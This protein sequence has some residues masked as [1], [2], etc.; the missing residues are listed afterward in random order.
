MTH[1][2]VCRCGAFY[3][4]RMPHDLCPTKTWDCPACEM[5]AL[6]DAMSRLAPPPTEQEL[7]CHES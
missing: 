4:C 3:V 7:N 5:Q 2:H 1:R 6:D